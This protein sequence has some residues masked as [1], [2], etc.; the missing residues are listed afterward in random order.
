MSARKLAVIFA[1]ILVI[2]VGYAFTLLDH[3]RIIHG[4]VVS[5]IMS[6]GL[7][8]E[9]SQ[10]LIDVI[11]DLNSNILEANEKLLSVIKV[12]AAQDRKIEALEVAYCSIELRPSPKPIDK[13]KI[14]DKRVLGESFTVADQSWHLSVDID[15]ML[16][17][18]GGD[19]LSS[20]Y[21]R[22]LRGE[23]SEDQ[24]QTL[25]AEN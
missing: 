24:M 20:L 3:D 12:M 2:L 16:D 1:F 11:N 14:Y 13:S 21:F 23:I 4:Q 15:E 25:L 18:D 6:S 8:V 5:S 7:N 9:S 10:E 19:T 22:M 17:V